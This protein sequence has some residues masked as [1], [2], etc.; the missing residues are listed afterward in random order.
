MN[1]PC[2]LHVSA[3]VV[4]ILSE[5]RYKEWV[6]RD[7]TKVCEPKQRCKILNF[8]NIWFKIILKYKIQIK[9]L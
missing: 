3:T 5:V 8:K 2:L 1:I 4:A 7:I 9:F 6:Y